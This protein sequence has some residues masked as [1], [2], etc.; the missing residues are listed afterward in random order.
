MSD[1][2][3]PSARA[4]LLFITAR[5][6]ADVMKRLGQAT[7][8]GELLAG[9]VLGPSL[10]G[11]LAPAFYRALFSADPIADHLLEAVAWIS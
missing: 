4:A 8:I 11:P 5:I 1:S 10:L 3:V 7:V 6:L 9:V 2:R